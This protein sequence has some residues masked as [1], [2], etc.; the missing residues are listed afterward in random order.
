MEYMFESFEVKL[1]RFDDPIDYISESFD[2][3]DYYME[4]DLIKGMQKGN[5][6]DRAIFLVK[7]IFSWIAAKCR[8]IVSYVK[9]LFKSKDVNDKTLDQIAEQVL[10]NNGVQTAPVKHM[11]FT[12]DDNQQIRFNLVSN[13]AKRTKTFKDQPEIV[14]HNP[15]DRPE[16]KYMEL[17]FHVIKKPHLLDPLIQFLKDIKVDKNDSRWNKDSIQKAID[18]FWAGNNM[19]P[20]FTFTLEEWT[21]LNERLQEFHQ[22]LQLV[23]DDTFKDE[24]QF[25]AKYADAMNQLVKIGGYL[26]KA[27]NSVGDG[28]RQVYEL[29]PGYHNKIDTTNYQTTLPLFVRLCVEANIPSKYI[30]HAVRQICNE[31][32]NYDIKNSSKG[33]DNAPVNGNG[34]FVMIPNPAKST[35]ANGLMDNNGKTQIIKIAYNGLGVRGN[36]NEVEILNIVQSKSQRILDELYGVTK[37]DDTFYVILGDSTIPIDNYKKCIEWNKK[38]ETM[39]KEDKIGFIIRCNEGGFGKQLQNGKET[40]KVI[41]IDYGTV[42]RLDR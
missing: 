3:L 35:Q 7:E 19:T 20:T 33:K 34:R 28:M 10:S 25:G 18:S 42:H 12:Y 32:I 21:A 23:D 15:K 11:R 37:M 27:I 4:A 24:K 40:G 5:F 38:M 26:Q 1:P 16:Q 14:G 17:L 29:D 30:I 31:D 8:E 6:L 39:C 36:R 9:S 22:A 2:V 13:L 41:C